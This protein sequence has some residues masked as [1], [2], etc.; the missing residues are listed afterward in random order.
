VKIENL[1]KLSKSKKHYITIKKGSLK[2][3]EKSIIQTQF[4]DL[5]IFYL[6]NT[7]NA[8]PKQK[9]NIK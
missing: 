3:V 4:R 8:W 1:R 9:N 2:S 7:Q 5:T 6:P